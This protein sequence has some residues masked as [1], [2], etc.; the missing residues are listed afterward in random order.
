[1]GISEKAPPSRF[2]LNEVLRHYPIVSGFAPGE[3]SVALVVWEKGEEYSQHF[4][5]QY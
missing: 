4:L 1:M 2:Q 3:I 5:A